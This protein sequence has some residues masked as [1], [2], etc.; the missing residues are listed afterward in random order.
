[1]ARKRKIVLVTADSGADER[2]VTLSALDKR[3]AENDAMFQAARSANKRLRE[4][5]ADQVEELLKLDRHAAATFAGRGK[6]G[7]RAS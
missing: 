2:R 3:R 4:T 5:I 7:R 6:R 1:M